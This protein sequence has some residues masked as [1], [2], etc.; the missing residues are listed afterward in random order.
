MST[1]VIR[2]AFGARGWR[3]SAPAAG[4]GSGPYRGT[5][6]MYDRVIHAIPWRFSW[7]ASLQLT[8]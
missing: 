8:E 1:A 6:S 5:H 2:R 7:R 4:S 3:L